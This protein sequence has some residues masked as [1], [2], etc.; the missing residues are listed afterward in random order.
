MAHDSEIIKEEDIQLNYEEFFAISRLLESHH[1]VF[2]QLW[3][4]GKPYFTKSIPTAAVSFDKQGDCVLFMFNP[5]FWRSLDDNQKCFIISHECMHVLLNHGKR[6]VDIPKTQRHGCN[7]SM[8][9]VINECLIKQFDF[10]QKEIDPEN[11]YCWL[12]TIYPENKN[13]LPSQNYEYYFNRLPSN[14]KNSKQILVDIHDFFEG[15]SSD[16]IFERLNDSLSDAEKEEINKILDKFSDSKEAS[17]EGDG[18]AKL[19]PKYN[20]KKKKW[21]SVIKKW[22][23]PMLKND[24]DFFDHWARSNR[25]MAE[26]PSEVILPNE[27][28]LQEKDENNRIPLYF[29]LDVSGSCS[30]LAERFWK[31]ASSIPK[32]SFDKRLF[33]FNTVV[34]E[35]NE[36]DRLLNVGGATRFDILEQKLQEDL[37]NKRIKIYPPAVFV[38]TDGYGNQI[39]PKKAEKWHWFLTEFSYKSYIPKES[40]IHELKNFE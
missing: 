23:L 34:E 32:E 27:M 33:S 22:T 28:E 13:I 39:K 24:F 7:I 35:V 12:E 2:Y 17:K 14:L 8:D 40:K 36:K 4:L 20:L 19:M 37:K 11:K 5:D 15:E 25:R 6:S 10:S 31:A 30:H 29:F 9:I 16:K 38:I 18:N 26:L 3:E 1:A 21:E